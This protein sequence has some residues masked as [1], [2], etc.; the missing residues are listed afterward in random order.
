MVLWALMGLFVAFRLLGS[1]RTV[2]NR[3]ELIVERLGKYHQTL[4]Q[5]I[6][7]MVPFVDRVAFRFES[8]EEAVEVPPQE[9]FTK[10]NVRVEVDGILYMK[11]VN[12]KLAAYGITDYRFGAIQLAQTTVRAVIGTLEL[13]RT[14]EEREVINRRVI[15]ALNEV[16]RTW[17]LEVSRYE[18]K[19]IVPP[20]SVREAME[21]QRAAETERRTAMARAEGEKVSRIADS[22][23]KK[24]EMINRSQGELQKR[25]NEAEGKAAEILAVAQ[26]T[27][28][29]IATIGATVSQPGGIDAVNL[30]LSQ[31]MLA[32]LGWLSNGQTVVLPMDLMSVDKLLD[33]VK[34]EPVPVSQQRPALPRP[35]TPA[36]APAMVARDRV[37]PATIPSMT[38]YRDD[39]RKG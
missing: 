9:C 34:L 3:T 18:V 12:T 32:R 19:N 2:P 22:E 17:G 28:E 37:V 14:F 24:Q 38:A 30:K 5:G 6:H 29:S 27:A 21:R 25:I 36:P 20:A 39:E 11:V 13:D 26:A 16:G 23:G 10:D 1:I 33:S 8:K 4:G 31:Q 35:S 15:D 7:F